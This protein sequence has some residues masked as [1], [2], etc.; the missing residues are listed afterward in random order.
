MA[1]SDACTFFFHRVQVHI[2]HAVELVM[3]IGK[4]GPSVTPHN[5]P[6]V[7]LKQVHEVLVGSKCTYSNLYKH[8]RKKSHH[9]STTVRGEDMQVMI[10]LEVASPST[11]SL[12][13]V[14]ASCALHAMV[15][16]KA[17]TLEVKAMQAIR[18]RT[19][20]MQCLPIPA[21]VIS[22]AP[23]CI[24]SPSTIRLTGPLPKTLPP[25]QLPPVA[26]RSYG[27]LA[28]KPELAQ[29]H[30]LQVQLS[31]LQAWCTSPIQLDR[32]GGFMAPGTHKHHVNNISLF[33]GH[34]HWFQGVA[35][36]DM[37]HYLDPL[38]VCDYISLKIAT[39]QSPDTINSV[40]D[41]AVVVLNWFKGQ[42]EA[43]QQSLSQGI[44]WLQALSSQVGSVQH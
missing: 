19:I 8:A 22:S 42:A 28:T 34:C 37:S 6:M 35:Q 18:D 2:P 29:V 44:I 13:V 11:P 36:P 7:S 30:P 20:S 3:L 12:L 38:K 9:C 15:S 33:L 21:H 17:G 16:G 23:T 14:S 10:R 39:S 25:F 4:P 27:L 24:P 43:D 41:T 40:L 5:P 26:K 1:T 32:P 31:Q